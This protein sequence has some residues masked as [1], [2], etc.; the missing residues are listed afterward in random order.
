MG[1]L[2]VRQVPPPLLEHRQDLGLLPGEQ[3][4]DRLVARGGVVEMAC[5]LA[6]APPPRPGPV[7]LEHPADPPER[8][9][10]LHRLVDQAQQDGLG[11]AVD[12]CRDR[13]AQPQAASPRRAAGSI[14]CSTIVADSRPTSLRR[15]VSSAVS[16]RLTLG[17]F[18]ATSSPWSGPR[19]SPPLP[20]PPS[21]V[22][23]PL[24]EARATVLG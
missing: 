21:V 5:G 10:C 12:S 14:A 22:E 11:G 2:A 4:V 3:P 23:R 13:A 24:G 7:E 16:T 20:L 19:P 15:P 8:P 6:M 18:C 9:A 17:R 1:E